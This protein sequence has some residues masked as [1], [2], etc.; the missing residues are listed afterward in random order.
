MGCLLARPLLDG[1]GGGPPRAASQA[2]PRIGRTSGTWRY[3]D[4]N[5]DHT[6]ASG[7]RPASA[8]LSVPTASTP[9]SSSEQSAV[10]ARRAAGPERARASPASR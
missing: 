2:S 4:P 9:A 10:A 7:K 3:P 5:P 8:A 6:V 1:G